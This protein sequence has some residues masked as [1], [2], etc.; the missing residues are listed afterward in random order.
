MPF[1]RLMPFALVLI[2]LVASVACT[3]S[4]RQEAVSDRGQEVMPFDL[5]RTTHR[6]TPRPDG[7]V[8]EVVAD[9]PSDTTQTALVRQ[10]LREEVNRFQAGDYGDPA[11]IHG[12]DMPG[13]AQLQAGAASIAVTYG[14][15]V[16]GVEISFVTPEPS[17]VDALHQWGEAQVTDHGAHAK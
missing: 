8:Q 17:L 4:N 1:R 2:A 12:D 5:D 6:F 16:A 10:H 3:S 15:T 13:L 14:D 11:Q 9:D 7:L